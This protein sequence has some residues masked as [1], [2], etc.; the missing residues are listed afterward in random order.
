MLSEMGLRAMMGGR[1]DGL[2][3]EDF[4]REL[5]F[6]LRE[7]R[8]QEASDRE[9][10][11]NIY[12]SGSAPPTVEGSLTAMGGMSGGVAARAGGLKEE[13]IMS[14]PA[15]LP[16]YYS[17][18]NLNPRLPPPVLSKEDWR[19][20]RRVQA[21]NS[22]PGGVGDGRNLGRI[23]EGWNK[24][25][26]SLQPGFDAKDDGEELRPG[27]G[28]SEWL[29]KRGDDLIGLP[30]MPLGR[31][32]SFADLFQDDQ[33]QRASLSDHP[34]H[35]ASQNAFDDCVDLLRSG[36]TLLLDGPRANNNVQ[37]VIVPKNSIA[38]ASPTFASVVGSS[39]SRSNTP[40]PQL[41]TRAPSP[42]LPPVGV[43]IGNSDMKIKNNSSSLDRTTSLVDSNDLISALS[44]MSILSSAT[45]DGNIQ[46][47][48][49][50]ETDD[51]KSSLL[52]FQNV[53]NNVK[54][55]TTKNSYCGIDKNST[56]FRDSNNP[57]LRSTQYIEMPKMCHPSN[58]SYLKGSSSTFRSSECSP[59]HFSR[60]SDGAN[61]SFTN[62]GLN[63]YSDN[64]FP[65]MMPNHVGTS[66]LRPPFE[67]AAMV[68]GLGPH[69]MEAMFLG[70]GFSS[71]ANFSELTDLH[72]LNKIGSHT[73]G[74]ALQM[75][76][77]PLYV[78]YLSAINSTDP[79]MERSTIDNSYPDSLDIQNAYVR[80]LLQQQKQ[81]GMPF[82]GKS[83]YYNNH[84][85]GMS[86]QGSPLA[87]S[88]L[89][90]SPI[91]LG[92]PFRHAERN[93]HFPSSMKNLVGGATG[94]WHL[95]N[96]DGIHDG[97]ASSLMEEFKNNKTKC[98]ELSDIAGHV[99]EFSTD[100]YG[101]RFI[102]QKLETATTKEK[103]LVFD[104][105]MPHAF[106][107]M[108][109]VFG[110]YVVQKFF[111]HGSSSQ[112]S[113]LADQ[114]GG[115]VLTLSLQMYGCRVIQKAIEVV[116]LDQQT[117]MVKEL[118]GH[119]MR[120]VR[121][122]NGNHVIQKCIECI[123]QDAI[124][125][126][127]SIFYDQVVTLSTHPYGCRVIQRVL[128]HCDDHKTQQIMMDEILGS[129]CMLAQDQYG[130]YV[131]QHVLEHGKPHERSVIIQKLAGQIVHMSQQK[132]ASNVVEKCLTFGGPDERQ[133]LVNE[134]LGSTDENEPLQACCADNTIAM[135]KDQFA[136][137]VVQKML[138]T[139]DDQQRQLILSR[140]KVHLNALKKYT[141]GKHIVAR[142]EKLVAAGVE[143][144]M[145]LRFRLTDTP[146]ERDIHLFLLRNSI[147]SPTLPVPCCLLNPTRPPLQSLQSTSFLLFRASHLRYGHFCSC[148][149]S[150]PRLLRLSV[151]RR[152]FSGTGFSVRRFGR[153]AGNLRASRRESPYEVLG[154][155]N[156]VSPEEIKKAYRKLALK[157]HPDVNK[158]PDA[159]EKF[160]RIK[161]AYNT[162]LSSGLQSKL[163]FGN[164]ASRY[165][166]TNWENRGGQA[167]QEEDFYGLGSAGD[168]P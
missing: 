50:K 88:I 101:S 125:F 156:S 21:G 142:V 133:Y 124:Q 150:P 58:N 17:N 39:L 19:L 84:S 86:Y 128:E 97:F 132:F 78:H 165:S 41:V 48:L 127:I 136:N 36:D 16:Y 151:H 7:Q 116:V 73:T 3:G 113:E 164:D 65:L 51:H 54:Q 67:S 162:L 26:F 168:L 135:M 120:C 161:H 63:G 34:S 24:S 111:E 35:I 32:K 112:R 9:R 37:N 8:R 77:D 146:P 42:R 55:Q 64:S 82:H 139:C 145:K 5:G 123:P 47:N 92:S 91:G 43:K 105:I 75:P 33:G 149:S 131:V 104:E 49:Q 70:G 31:Q 126:I 38:L 144:T 160:M 40:D 117:K 62:H 110:N 90:T 153:G 80:V 89:P 143:M 118:D 76:I 95:D 121:D 23:D 138:E 2:S 28:S 94:S 14:D 12:R 157:Y 25:L 98:Y 103:D 102:Q 159:Q 99:A 147:S 87:S 29:S 137:Y 107:L 61:T 46:S 15:Y 52:D 154:V 152:Q 158:E 71:A 27:H 44:G 72:S 1:G 11:L 56:S 130:N 141:Y 57:I 119:I 140:I 79:S 93:L 96:G 85:F 100:Q 148:N 66:N 129:I 106:S 4:G 108:T 10:E 30:G 122:Q 163:G 18:V 74:S 69:A 83:S 115:H 59:A 68:S 166:R 53:P 22:G 45:V 109:D 81:F 60:S 134:M 167:S 114:L 20:A 13:E 155:P 6:L